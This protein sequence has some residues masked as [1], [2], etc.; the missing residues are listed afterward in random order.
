MIIKKIKEVGKRMDAKSEKLE[1]LTKRKF[2]E[3]QNRDEEHTNWN[4]KYTGR[5]Q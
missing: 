5:N 1:V 3:Q 2:K 4:E